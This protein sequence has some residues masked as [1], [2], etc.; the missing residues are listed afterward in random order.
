[1]TS[2]DLQTF[3]FEAPF[4]NQRG[5]VIERRAR[6]AQFF[7]QPIRGSTPLRMVQV[8]GGM[9]QMGS[10]RSFNLD[11][12]PQHYVQVAPFAMSDFLITQS[13][14]QGLMGKLPQCRFHDPNL[15]LE[16]V[17]W[18][19]AMD[20][21]RHLSQSSGRTYRLPSEAEWEF[22]CR[23]GTNTPFSTGVT[24][25]TDYANYVGDHLFAEEP[26]GIYRHMVTPV[27][28]FPPNSFGLYDLHGNLWEFCADRWHPDYT[29]APF[30]STMWEHG[31]EQGYCVARGGSWH[32][33]PS[34]CRSAVR[35]RVRENERDDF[36]GFRVATSLAG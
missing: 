8:S 6:S 33:T 3:E 14:W 31:G 9:F 17:C 29:G 22:A 19:D 18:K 11:E 30:G 15:P 26:Q 2:T 20:F 1:L 28:T 16:N 10:L 25:T 13:Q 4:L 23:A 21:C 35:L 7:L 32:E 27:Q 24:I 5:E 34:N 36:Y 12:T